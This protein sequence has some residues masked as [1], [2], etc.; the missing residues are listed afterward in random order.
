VV[1]ETYL[2][3]NLLI[4]K[5]HGLP[6]YFAPPDL[7]KIEQT[8]LRPEAVLNYE[9]MRAKAKLA[10]LNL[11]IV[12]GFRPA[13]AQTYLYSTATN[14]RAAPP[15]F[16]EHQL[17]TAVDLNVKFLSP[18]WTWLVNNAHLFGFVLSYPPNQTTRTGYA[19]EPWHWRFVGKPLASQIRFSPNLPQTFYQ[20]GNCNRR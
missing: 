2:A 17:G 4:D 10:G 13:S 19:F 11:K 5:F 16:S 8:Y 15:G 6:T 1:C 9:N 7:I 14:L 12:S 20:T 3:L 18:E